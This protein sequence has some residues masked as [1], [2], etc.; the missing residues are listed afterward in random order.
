MAIE[1]SLAALQS[2]FARPGAVAFE[3]SPLGGI[4]ARLT[5]SGNTS[6]IALQGAQV[7]SW[8][9]GGFERLWLS[10]A[11][12][13]GTGKAVRG[14]I[15]VC[16]PWFAAHPHDDTK[17]FHG[18]VRTRPWEVVETGHTEGAAWIKLSYETGI[19]D[20]ALWPQEAEAQLTVRLD[21]D[22]SL[23]LLTS[24]LGEVGFVMSQALHTYFAVSDIAQVRIEGLDEMKYIDKLDTDARKV[25]SGDITIERE[26]D[27]IYLGELG[28]ITLVDGAVPQRRIATKSTGSHSAVVWNPWIEKTKRL[29]DMG[30][31]DAYKRMLCIESTNAGDDIV[32]V[33]PGADHTISVRYQVK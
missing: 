9:A 1:P 15:P 13:L 2:A 19:A 24:N 6:T 29:G 25:Q 20:L 16:W 5:A 22:L 8:I 30:S 23:S 32:L 28:T 11:A 18:F 27:R 26:V 3:M 10:P 4:V 17:P 7:L 14:G 31:D 33:P 21:K 12:R